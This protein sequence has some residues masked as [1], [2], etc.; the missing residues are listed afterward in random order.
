MSALDFKTKTEGLLSP[1]LY[2]CKCAVNAKG[3][4]VSAE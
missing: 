3:V 1:F 2:W 4:T